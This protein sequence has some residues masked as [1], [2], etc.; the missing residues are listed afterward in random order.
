[1]KFMVSLLETDSTKNMDRAFFRFEFRSVSHWTDIKQ[2]QQQQ[3]Q[4]HKAFSLQ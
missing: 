2:Q 3:Q 1:M 4:Q